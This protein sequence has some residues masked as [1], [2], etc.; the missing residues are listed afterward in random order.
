MQSLQSS[1]KA[2]TTDHKEEYQLLD[3]FDTNFVSIGAFAS[4]VSPKIA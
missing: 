3:L 2:Y 4:I 1:L